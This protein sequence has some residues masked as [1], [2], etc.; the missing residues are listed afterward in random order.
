MLRV[1]EQS[2]P[3]LHIQQRPARLVLLVFV[4]V[5]VL[6]WALAFGSL[7]P[8]VDVDIPRSGAL[9]GLAMAA[10]AAVAVRGTTDLV[11][12]RSAGLV[13][14][15]TWSLLG[16]GTRQIPLAA[17][18][19]AD[20]ET[21]R[22]GTPIAPVEGIECTESG[23][24]R[25]T[26]DAG[27]ATDARHRREGRKDITYAIRFV[28]KPGVPLDRLSNGQ[29]LPEDKPL[30]SRFSADT[31]PQHPMN[32]SSSALADWE[33]AARAINDWMGVVSR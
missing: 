1:V 17:V 22:H 27:A 30:S 4:P 7:H 14:R 29:P 5:P 24:L 33:R 13:T 23:A 21:L 12:D 25:L 20:V 9:V 19:R 15:R 28:L 8:W 3:R 16:S 2:A 6:L 32:V 31:W 10:V 11:L 18:V 26:V